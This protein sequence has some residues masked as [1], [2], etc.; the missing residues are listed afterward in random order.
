ML[1]SK[2]PRLEP[3]QML[4]SSAHELEFEVQISITDCEISPSL[5]RMS[6]GRDILSSEKYLVPY[7]DLSRCEVWINYLLDEN[8]FHK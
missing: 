3:K 8:S 7:Y 2:G 5:G 6:I 4:R 1:D